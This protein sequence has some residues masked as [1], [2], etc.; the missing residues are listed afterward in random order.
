MKKV[1]KSKDSKEEIHALHATKW[2]QDKLPVDTDD[3]Q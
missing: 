2:N 3:D 1:Q